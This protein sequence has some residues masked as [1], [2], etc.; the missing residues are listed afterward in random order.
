MLHAT[1]TFHF[2]FQICAGSVKT[3]QAIEAQVFVVEGLTA[4]HDSKIL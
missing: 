3:A 2:F 1:T 4:F